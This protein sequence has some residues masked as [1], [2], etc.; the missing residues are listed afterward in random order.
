M[1]KAR[2]RFMVASLTR[3]DVL[4]CGPRF[5]D[6]AAASCILGPSPAI[7][8]KRRI[9]SAA[10][11]AGPRCFA[12]VVLLSGFSRIDETQEQAI[13]GWVGIAIRARRRGIEA[14]LGDDR[15][16]LL[17]LASNRHHFALFLADLLALRD[18]DDGKVLRIL[19]AREIGVNKVGVG[20]DG[21]EP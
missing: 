5:R 10:P 3:D 18:R 7:E 12:G 17:V 2:L 9:H 19:L 1:L 14:D 20:P 11:L 21:H 13:A 4:Q 16:A 6:R 15:F 8:R